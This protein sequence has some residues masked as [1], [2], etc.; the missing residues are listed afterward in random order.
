VK[1]NHLTLTVRDYVRA[2]DWYVGA[3][4]LVLEFEHPERGFGALADEADFGLLLQE[5]DPAGNPPRLALYF[6]VE[7]VDAFYHYS[8]ARGLAFDHEPRTE[9]WGYGP[10]VRDPDGYV[11]RFWDQRSAAPPA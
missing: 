4:G 2:R 1:L 10:Q 9:V 5:G 7:D 3:L 8:S 11:L 6:E